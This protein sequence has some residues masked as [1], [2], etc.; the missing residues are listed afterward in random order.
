MA[1]DVI[2]RVRAAVAYGGDDANE[3]Y[4]VTVADLR[5]LLAVAEAA[6]VWDQARRRPCTLTSVSVWRT[7]VQDAV[8]ALEAA[9]AAMGAG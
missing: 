6:R 9:V 5:T 3:A 7:T 8:N 1:D 4:N 2:G